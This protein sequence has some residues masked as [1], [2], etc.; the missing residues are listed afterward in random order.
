MSNL[1]IPADVW[2]RE[3]FEYE[4]CA[5]CGGDAPDHDAIAFLG[6]WFA[7]CRRDSCDKRDVASADRLVYCERCE[8]HH[9]Q[10]DGHDVPPPAEVTS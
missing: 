5:E 4:Y 3:Q 8:Y 2:L 6:N 10:N 9:S 1:D 7:R